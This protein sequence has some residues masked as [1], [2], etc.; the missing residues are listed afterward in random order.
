MP[1][2]IA[3]RH[4]QKGQHLH[5]YIF[6]H[7]QGVAHYKYYTRTLQRLTLN[8]V[9]FDVPYYTPEMSPIKKNS[10]DI[11]RTTF[12]TQVAR[13]AFISITRIYWHE[14]TNVLWCERQAR[15]SCET[16]GTCHARYAALGWMVPNAHLSFTSCTSSFLWSPWTLQEAYI[17]YNWWSL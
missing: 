11:W 16:P 14:S 7:A 13:S 1:I 10:K 6:G 17:W 3:S 2:I 4:Q 12:G 8:I 15:N 5:T 9:T